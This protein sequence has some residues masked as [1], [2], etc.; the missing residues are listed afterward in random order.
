MKKIAICLM[1]SLGV[2]TLLLYIE[3]TPIP[4]TLDMKLYDL[5][6]NVRQPPVQDQRI[7][8]VEMDEETIDH[9]GRWPWPRNIFAN[10]TDTL[11]SLEARQIIFDVTF[12]QPN[13]VFI[14]KDAVNH[15]FQG[16]D[17]IEH[18]IE[19]KAG[20]IKGMDTIPQKDALGTLNQIRNGFLE[21]TNSAEK[22][23]QNALIDN[24][25]ILSAS[26][27]SSNTFIGYSFEV[28][29]EK[30][31][32]DKNERYPQIQEKMTKWIG[33]N[34]DKPFHELPPT[35]K[36]DNDFSEAE[37][38]EIFL[39][40]RIRVLIQ[41]NMETSLNNAA[42]TL[43]IPPLKLKKDFNL[44]KHKIIEEQ[45]RSVLEQNP[46]AQFLED[47]IFRF[48][49]FEEDTRKSY[50]EVWSKVAKEF[51]A[52]VKFGRLLPNE[53]VFFIAKNFEAPVTIFTKAVKGGG[54]LNGIPDPDGV[55]RSIPLFIK[56]QNKIF[57]H[58]AVTS[59][60]DLYKPQKI[61]FDAGKSFI[62]HHA[63]V[64][65]QT[66]DINIPIDH[67]GTMLINWTGRF[68]NTFRHISASDIYRLYFMRDELKSAPSDTEETVKLKK[69]TAAK[70]K[71][72]KEKIKGSICIIGLTAPG[73]HDYNPIPYESAYPMVGTHGSVLN[74][75]LTGQFIT[76]SPRSTNIIILLG[77]AVLI[78]LSLTFLSSLNGLFCIAVILAGTFLTALYWFNQGIW[79]HL[80]SPVLCC[81]MSYLGIT[82]YKF[83]TEEKSKREIKSAFSKY[84]SPDVIEEIMKDP[85][86]LQLG[87][88]QRTLSVMFSDIRSFTTYCEKRKPE[89]IVSILNEYLDA[90]TKVIVEHKGTLDKY[91]GDEIMAVFGAPQYEPP[92]VNAQRA[93]ICGM[94]MLERLKV[95]H[96][97]WQER[98][99][100]PLDIGIGVNTGEMV[101]GNMGS[102]LRMDY[103]VIGDA[104]NLG[105]RVEAL[106]REFKCYFI[107]SEFTYNYVKD[108][109][110][111]K[112]LQ[113]IKVKGKTIPVMVYE[114]LALKSDQILQTS[115][116]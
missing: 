87:G 58:I 116:R 24:D 52:E 105:A 3:N 67:Q 21:F 41:N 95:L 15:I 69:E 113:S 63:D 14:N 55:L 29:T 46:D 112:P 68:K 101:V 56:Y 48:E 94:K 40:S 31:D 1:I 104:V 54:F 49:I 98:G 62:L 12:S 5:L 96:G 32:I 22:K 108:I 33:N 9:L 80:A 92:E 71:T 44:V 16:K 10:I 76:R 100:E 36:E 45:M 99:L 111:V 81:L 57:P 72:L 43:N 103:T 115:A 114:V 82:S 26:F 11:N 38:Q 37:L 77:L 91:V 59:I 88:V 64:A 13:Q 65:G 27:N 20:V 70:E 6:M 73:T 2:A 8:F 23:L 30:K 53:Q 34:S 28:L 17:E 60:L 35:Y 83:S 18:Y 75:I 39:R 4:Q 78:G 110:D 79:F 102:E 66:K 107:I 84:V 86:K 97:E 109:V 50:Q 25:E 42:D 93:V 106:T 51:A 74:S 85:S 47:I 7:L 90:M 61:S 89:E 19:D